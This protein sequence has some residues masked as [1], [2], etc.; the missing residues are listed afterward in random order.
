VRRSPARRQRP[1]AVPP[2]DQLPQLLRFGD[3]VIGLRAVTQMGQHRGE[4]PAGPVG[5]AL[6]LHDRDGRSGQ[7]AVG[8]TAPRSRSPSSPWLT[9]DRGPVDA[10]SI[11][12]SRSGSAGP[13]SQPSAARAAGQQLGEGLAGGAPAQRLAQHDQETVGSSRHCRSTGGP[14]GGALTQPRLVAE[15]DLVQDLAWLLAIAWVV[16]RPCLA[17]S[18]ASAS[19]ISSGRKARAW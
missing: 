4:L 19:S 17:A 1:D 9:S 16:G 7:A 14:T 8:R 2:P 15:P 6:H 12:P 18:A 5:V 10:Y 13:R 3:Q 11:R